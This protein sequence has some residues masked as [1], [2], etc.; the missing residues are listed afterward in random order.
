M[1]KVLLISISSVFLFACSPEKEPF[2]QRTFV[3][4]TPRNQGTS[5][6]FKPIHSPVAELG[7]GAT[8]NACDRL[9]QLEQIGVDDENL[10]NSY[11][12]FE[13]FDAANKVGETNITN[14][15]SEFVLTENVEVPS[16][17]DFMALAE[18]QYANGAI[19]WYEILALRAAHSTGIGFKSLKYSTVSGEV[20]KAMPGL[21]GEATDVT[22][23]LYYGLA[24]KMVDFAQMDNAFVNKVMT[25]KVPLFAGT[26]W[27]QI[28]N[29]E[30]TTLRSAL[31]GVYGA[32][33]SFLPSED[34]LCGY[35]LMQRSFSQLLAL[36]GQF[37]T[38]KNEAGRLDKISREG[39]P[40]LMT[41]Q[42]GGFLNSEGIPVV[43]S[44]ADIATYSP[45]QPLVLRKTMMDETLPS[46]LDTQLK[47]LELMTLMLEA[48][49]PVSSWVGNKTYLFGDT[50]NPES[51][52]IAPAEAHS[53]SL[54]L[55]LIGFK[56][57][58][59]QNLVFTNA[60][61]QRLSA[62]ETAAG[63]ALID[64]QY[65]KG[66][67]SEIN[68]ESV[69]SLMK[70]VVFL[71][72]LLD[73]MAT[74]SPEFL[75]SMNSALNKKTL[76][77]LVGR[78]MFSKTQLDEILTTEE[79]KSILRNSLTDLQ[80]PL[81]LMLKRFAKTKGFCATD[82]SWNLGTGQVTQKGQCS[83]EQIMMVFEGLR[84]MGNKTKTQFL[85]DVENDPE[86]AIEKALNGT[87]KL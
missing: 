18:E 47:F 21:Y 38:V 37:A 8:V 43:L 86:T 5:D 69:V 7:S 23:S 4:E 65:A 16:D 56:N 45:A 52:A 73:E 85:I 24:T 83:K 48:S 68:I 74:K 78:T 31:A 55:L 42:P 62:G 1:K 71:S 9:T 80:Y 19:E 20:E 58:A 27:T 22:S 17:D 26:S 36:K 77:Q 32:S 82:I 25:Q 53:L 35:V 51:A 66:D 29:E 54:G 2:Q 61:G 67:L 39:R 33:N 3:P 6:A 70:T 64:T 87:I 34:K 11:S 46:D 12:L 44:P 75:E 79:Q 59:A 14:P 50:T 76:A 41:D 15:F 13:S 84:Y 63:F 10:S 30:M 49:S 28:L 72:N 40:F 57:L 81:V 60:K